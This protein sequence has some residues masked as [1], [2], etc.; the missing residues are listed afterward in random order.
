M[1]VCV[2]Y[3]PGLCCDRRFR[4]SLCPSSGSGDVSNESFV[5]SVLVNSVRVYKH[6]LGH[7]VVVVASLCVGQHSEYSQDIV[8]LLK[9]NPVKRRFYFFDQK[10]FNNR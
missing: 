10:R 5:V 3:F 9:I 8:A 7:V 2:E 1:R 4:T 6:F